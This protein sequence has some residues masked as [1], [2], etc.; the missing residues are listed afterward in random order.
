MPKV[1]GKIISNDDK[2]FISQIDDSQWLITYDLKSILDPLN[3]SDGYFSRAFIIK[4]VS[5]ND[6]LVFQLL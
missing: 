2:V 5:L 4:S 1:E 6:I 3:I